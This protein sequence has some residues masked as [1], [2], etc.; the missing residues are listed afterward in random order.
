MTNLRIHKA[1][2]TLHGN[3]IS[4]EI[5]GTMVAI[6]IHWIG[7]TDLFDVKEKN[8]FDKFYISCLYSSDVAF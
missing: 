1:K 7:H 8:V 5:T 2:V 4:L 6:E 3:G